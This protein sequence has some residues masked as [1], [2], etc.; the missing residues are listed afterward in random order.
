MQKEPRAILEKYWGHHDFRGSQKS[1]IDT[2]ISGKDVLALLPTGGG[3]SV[4]YQIPAMSMDGICVVISP[5]VALIQDQVAQLKK[6]NI[7]AIALTG[8]IPFSELN[9]LLDN[10][11]YGNYKF[12]Y[13]S[14]ERLKQSIV[15]ER[16]LQMQINLVAMDEAH[17]ISQW[18]NDFRPAYLECASIRE[19]V[20]NIPVIAL[21]ATATP[22]VV[23]DIVSNLNL[24]QVQIFKDS[25][26]RSNIVFKVK[27][28][29]DK[30]YQLKKY[31]SRNA[32]ST[33]VYVRSRK[34]SVS[35]AKFIG[36]LG[37]RAD[38]FHGGLSNM[39]KTQKLDQWISGDN[40][41]MVATNAFGMGVDKPDVRLVVHYQIPDS[42]ESY[43]Q[44]AGRAG[45]DG[46]QSTAIILF[47]QED[48][49]RAKQQFLSSLPSISFIKKLYVKLCN[50]FQVSYGECPS[51]PMA[52][53][54]GEFCNRYEFNPNMALNGLRILDQHSVI[55]LT[56]LFN[57]KVTLQFVASRVGIFQYLEKNRKS[58]PLIKTV[59]RTYGGITEHETKINLGLL[60]KKSNETEKHIKKVLE[61]L[62]KDG[63]AEF[64]YDTSDLQLHFLVP[65]EDDRTINPFGKKIENHN[66]VKRDNMDAML[67]YLHVTKT[68]R[69]VYLLEY[70]GEKDSEDCGTCD[71]CTG[72]K[73]HRSGGNLEEK[74]MEILTIR[75]HSSRALEK[76]TGANEKTLLRTLQGML[77]DEL[78]V[79]NQ[80]NE[81]ILK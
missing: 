3:K 8:G 74:V 43:F 47:Q 29:E 10:C 1:I 67:K 48:E 63:V 54:F 50:Y 9:D 68:C 72:K 65:R 44:E 61:Q 2:V 18:G 14:P 69:S 66:A 62:H 64:K 71:I 7:K 42:L 52:L 73:K 34:M 41:V 81:Y 6:K 5:L 17:C 79:L 13:L 30:Q 60:S 20:P 12:L 36:Q 58:A 53:K 59:L 15:Q 49:D 45:R 76:L 56:E 77:E 35:L 37:V 16:L 75:P 25:F 70:F 11:V 57:E 23:E 78:I 39:E 31:L 22:K 32:G 46:K 51:E 55:S 21:T 28:T 38:F 33:I 80:K 4:C 27:A 24:K 26:L 19:L 40:R